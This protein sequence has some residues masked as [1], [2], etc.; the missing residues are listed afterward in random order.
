MELFYDDAHAQPGVDREAVKMPIIL[1][2]FLI[3]T[4][5]M[6]ALIFAATL[7]NFGVGVGDIR[8]VMM[9]AVVKM[10]T[11]PLLF[12]WVGLLLVDRKHTIGIVNLW[13]PL[14]TLAIFSALPLLPFSDRFV[15][16]MGIMVALVSAIF[17]FVESKKMYMIQ[18]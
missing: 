5:A 14:A 3:F 12:L 7:M 9:V 8:S 2:T 11:M 17:V 10:T 4:Y 1:N 6:T 15:G 18:Q 13:T 16:G